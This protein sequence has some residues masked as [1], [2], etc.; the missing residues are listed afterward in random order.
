MTGTL[1]NLALA[2]SEV[3][4][5][6]VPH[7]SHDG[8]SARQP[9]RAVYDQRPLFWLSQTPASRRQDEK[10]EDRCEV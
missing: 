5:T 4:F 1:S 10:Q 7:G 6:S 2:S 8:Q 9:A 3:E